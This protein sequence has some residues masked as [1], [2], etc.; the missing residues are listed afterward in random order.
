MILLQMIDVAWKEHLY[1]LDQLKKGIS[2]RAYAQKDPLIEF[3]KEAFEL[4][5]QMMTRIREQTLEY[6]FKVQSHAAMPPTE[7]ESIHEGEEQALPAALQCMPRSVFGGARAE[8]P[9]F[10]SQNHDPDPPDPI[11]CLPTVDA[12][13]TGATFSDSCRGIRRKI[14]ARTFQTPAAAQCLNAPA[15]IGPHNDPLLLRQR[16]KIQ[17]VSRP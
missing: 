9:E 3:Q 13:H 10:E 15:K 2:L 12:A 6:F 7:G 4:F 16:K 8:K 17:E 14:R 1:D 11:K 5:S